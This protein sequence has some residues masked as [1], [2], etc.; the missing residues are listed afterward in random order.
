MSHL[1]SV[2]AG[3]IIIHQAE[4]RALRNSYPKTILYPDHVMPFRNRFRNRHWSLVRLHA[5]HAIDPKEGQSATT[6]V[7]LPGL[8]HLSA[9]FLLRCVIVVQVYVCFQIFF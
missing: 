3:S 5:D 1:W 7:Q 8:S 4:I 2:R 6:S 9:D